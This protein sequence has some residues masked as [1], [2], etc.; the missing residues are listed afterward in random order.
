LA[1]WA[2]KSNFFPISGHIF[3]EHNCVDPFGQ[4]SAG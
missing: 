4:S 3:L 2:V 1:Q